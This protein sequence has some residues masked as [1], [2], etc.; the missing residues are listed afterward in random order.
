VKTSENSKGIKAA[1]KA[2]KSIIKAKNVRK[3]AIWDL[4]PLDIIMPK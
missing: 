3:Y 1:A 4:S 2:E